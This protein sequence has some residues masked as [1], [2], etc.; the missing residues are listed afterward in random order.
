MARKIIKV[1]FADDGDVIPKHLD[2]N[3]AS[4]AALMRKLDVGQTVTVA[5]YEREK[6]LGDMLMGYGTVTRRTLTG[7][8][9]PRRLHT[10]Y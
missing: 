5:V 4:Y 1:V 3:F 8:T 9:V 6:T 7:Y 10:E 2:K